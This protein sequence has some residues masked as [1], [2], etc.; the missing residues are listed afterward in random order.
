MLRYQSC[1]GWGL[2]G[3]QVAKQ[4]VSSYLAFPPLPAKAGGISLLHSPWSRLHRMLSGILSCG[5][6]TF[7]VFSPRSFGPLNLIQRKAA[8]RSFRIPQFPCRWKPAWPER[9][10]APYCIPNTS[11]PPV[12]PWAL[13]YAAAD[14]YI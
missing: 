14:F 11:C 5:A 3:L 6:R 7:L 1:S 9:W 12:L 13:S 4:P 2:Q 10:E 8:W